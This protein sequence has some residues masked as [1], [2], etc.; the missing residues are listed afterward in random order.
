MLNA[1][2]RAMFH[3]HFAVFFQQFDIAFAILFATYSNVSI[4]VR[5]Y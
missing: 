2:V 1:I 4:R 3:F 5:V